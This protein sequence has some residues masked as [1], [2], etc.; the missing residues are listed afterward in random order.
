MSIHG[1]FFKCSKC[2]YQSPVSRQNITIVYELFEG[3][4]V[5]SNPNTG[6]CDNCNSVQ[7]IEGEIETEGVKQRLAQLNAQSMKFSHQIM[8]FFRS[9]VGLGDPIELPL[10]AARET[11]RF[12]EYKGQRACCLQCGSDKTQAL[13][14]DEDG[15]CIS[16][17]HRCGGQLRV[18]EDADNQ[19]RLM[20]RPKM[21]YLDRE[22]KHQ[23]D[24]LTP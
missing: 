20:L 16:M 6:W 15:V 5:E 3:I 22:G 13:E 24:C 11:L 4:D 2:D 1:A 10:R 9:V 17:P 23:E 18:V 8:R 14:F 21:I 12:A 19:T 7:L